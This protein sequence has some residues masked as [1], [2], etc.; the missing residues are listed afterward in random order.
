MTHAS[1]DW[2]KQIDAALLDLDEKP[3]FALPSAVPLNR[4]EEILCKL[5]ARSFLKLSHAEKGWMQSKQLFDGL[6]ENISTLTIEWTPLETPLY[7]VV[8]EQ[9][10]K[11]LMSDLLGG[12]KAATPFFD[13]ELAEG[14]FH[15]LALEVLQAL[16]TLKYMAPLS[17]R[18]GDTPL[19]IRKELQNTKCFISDVSLDLGKKTIWGRILIPEAFRKACKAQFVHMRKPSLGEEG[20]GRVPVEITFDVGETQLSIEE[21]KNVKLGDFVILDRCSYNPEE[22]K[23][24]VTLNLGGQPI[25]RGRIKSGGVKISDYPLYQEVEN[26]MDEEM[27]EL[28][29]EDEKIALEG[30]FVSKKQD[31]E[32]LPINLK[33]EVGRVRMTVQELTELSP[34]NLIELNVAPE[35]GVD[36]VVNGKKVGKGELIRM[37]ESLG[38]RIL[39]F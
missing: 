26:T 5:F 29:V 32:K 20:M 17:P 22:K 9:D 23:G 30:N 12:M 11:E 34:G 31:F 15:Y 21:W 24:G 36:L 37:G 13:G 14:F 10:L 4:L 33:V 28:E 2:I 1:L 8:S 16:E 35:Q 18:I 3:Q 25:F 7:F 39:S 27:E 38:V 6:G 19:D